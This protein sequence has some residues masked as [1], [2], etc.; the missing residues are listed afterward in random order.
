MG[1]KVS[2]QQRNQM[3]FTR[4]SQILQYKSKELQLLACIL[5]FSWICVLYAAHRAVHVKTQ[6]SVASAVVYRFSQPPVVLLCIC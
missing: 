1:D 4:L 5:C 3:A 6:C 2:M